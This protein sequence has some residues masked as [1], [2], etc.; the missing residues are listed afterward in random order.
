LFKGLGDHESDRLALMADTIVLEQMQPLTEIRVDGASVMSICETRRVEMREHTKNARRAFRRRAIDG[1]NAAVRDRAPDDHA[2]R[3]AGLVE[4]GC[5]GGAA[6][7]LLAAIDAADGLS[8]EG[9]A[10]ARAPAV[11]TARTI[12][13]CISSILK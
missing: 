7:D 13:R 10:H 1:G 9:G 2:V 11:S 6:C 3:L 4:F 8:D 5:V 12:A